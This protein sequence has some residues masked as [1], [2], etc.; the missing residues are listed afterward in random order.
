MS[1]REV[2]GQRVTVVGAARSGEA[3]ARLLSQQDAAVFVTEHAAARPGQRET[4]EEY[5]IDYEFE[6]HTDRALDA[7]FITVSPGVPPTADIVA[8]ARN[9]DIPIYG[10]LEVASWFC[11]APIVAV[12]GTNGKTTTT[13]LLEHIFRTG[14]H[15]HRVA[16]NIGVPFSGVVSDLDA[17][18][19][20]ILEVSSFQ[21]DDIEGF[22]PAVSILLNIT[23]DHLKRY[24]GSFDAY[25]RS[26]CRIFEN[27]R[28]TDVLIY[29]DDDRRVKEAVET[30]ADARAPQLL[31]ISCEHEVA[32]GAFVRSGESDQIVLRLES[33]EEDLMAVH[34]LALRGRHNTYNSLAAAAAARV[35][36]IQ[37]DV[38]RRSLQTFQGVEHRLE[39]VREVGGVLYVND[40]KA[41]NVNAVWYAL[42]SFERPIVLI[43]G[44]RDKGNDY[45][46]LRPLVSERVR[47]VIALGESADKVERELG[48]LVPTSRRVSSM[49]EAVREAAGL[50]HSGDIVLLSPACS[51]FDM[52]DDYEHRGRVFKDAVARL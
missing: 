7:D 9:R 31:A 22:R 51:S 45:S 44:G 13:R 32:R 36:D 2:S 52:F 46:L 1:L 18:S 50:A 40:S 39:A 19:T 16:G 14:K 21:L 4:F 23:P 25:T 41:T 6:G 27:Q 29:N 38:I 30:R 17:D 26:K 35:C 48:Q 28:P 20:A 24:G 10:E 34:E 49:D 12:T 8:R 3:A 37:N 15:P 42:E 33:Q 47:A 43:A 5:G 11:N